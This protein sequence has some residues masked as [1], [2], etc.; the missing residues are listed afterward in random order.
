MYTGLRDLDLYRGD[1]DTG[2][3]RGPVAPRPL[4][5][6]VLGP[7]GGPRLSLGS[8]GGEMDLLSACG[9]VLGL[10]FD[11]FFEAGVGEGDLGSS[12]FRFRWCWSDSLPC[13]LSCLGD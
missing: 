2:G 1:C 12:R 11:D 7:L 10:V 5:L 6:G 8:V 4:G 13:S 3:V 9:G